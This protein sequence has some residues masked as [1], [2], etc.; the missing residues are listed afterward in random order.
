MLR[1]EGLRNVRNGISRNA[2]GVAASG[3]GVTQPHFNIRKSTM[4]LMQGHEALSNRDRELTSGGMPAGAFNI[5]IIVVN[6]STIKGSG[7]GGDQIFPGI[8]P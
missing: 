6:S 8:Q 2:Q 5:P 7:G 4:M 1:H 3:S